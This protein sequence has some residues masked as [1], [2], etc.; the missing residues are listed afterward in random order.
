MAIE[1]ILVLIDSSPPSLRTLDDAVE[2]VRPC[3]ARLTILYVV[4]R[5]YY[6]S[7]LLLVTDPR[8]CFLQRAYVNEGLR[9][10]KGCFLS[11]RTMRGERS[12]DSLVA[13]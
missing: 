6:G 5:A 4:E 13:N 8:D 9:V 10:T 2:L 7:P 12:H 1:R 11:V 3:E